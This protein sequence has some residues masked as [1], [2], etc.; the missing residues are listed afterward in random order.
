MLLRHYFLLFGVMNIFYGTKVMVIATITI[1]NCSG[2]QNMMNN[3]EETYELGGNIDCHLFGDFEPIGISDSFP[4]NG[5][6]DG[7]NL[8]IFGLHINTTGNSSFDDGT[9]LI[10]VLGSCEGH[11]VRGLLCGNG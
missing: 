5:T 9:G 10:G 3:L 8:T 11:L 4:F 6:L 1:G 2:L 7:K